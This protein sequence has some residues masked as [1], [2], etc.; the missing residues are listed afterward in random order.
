MKTVPDGYWTFGRCRAE[1][2][3]YLNRRDFR[4]ASS[5]Y[6]KASN[7]GWLEEICGHMVRLGSVSHRFVYVIMDPF[8]QTAYVGLTCNPKRR[9][10]DHANRGPAAGLL[11]NG[12]EM[13]VISDLLP[14][15]EAAELE[16]RML[17]E[18]QAA[19]IAV[20]N[21][22][23]GGGLGGKPIWTFERCR[24]ETS[25]Y[26][27]RTDFAKGSPGAYSAAWKNSWLDELCGH[28][29]KRKPRRLMKWDQSTVFAEAAKY[30]SRGEFAKRSSGAYQCAWKQ[31]W[32][33]RACRHMRA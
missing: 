20:L 22:M 26:A 7:K 3:K 8:G 21:K 16:I 24:S 9:R 31:G 19:G 11:R 30:Q 25:K 33:E 29:P 14:T 12:A 4:A 28:M 17:R 10:K 27:T 13:R 18:F 32:L 2:A 6:A 1:A 23:K 5:A 15:A